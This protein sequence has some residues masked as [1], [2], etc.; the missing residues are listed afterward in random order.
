MKG[1]ALQNLSLLIEAL[2][3]ANRLP[4]AEIA[5]NPQL[6][7]DIKNI[8]KTHNIEGVL[9]QL[10]Q[11]LS[12]QWQRAE[13]AKALPALN[14]DSI[15]R[16]YAQR[17]HER[18]K[19]ADA[20]VYHTK[21]VG[22]DTPGRFSRYFK[23]LA[24]N[25][26]TAIPDKA[27]G[28]AE[29]N[30]ETVFNTVWADGAVKINVT[31]DPSLLN[32]YMDYT[33]YRV[34]YATYLSIPTLSEM[35][36]R[37]LDL[38]F[39]KFAKVKSPNKKFT[40]AAEQFFKDEQIPSVTRDALFFALMS[41]R[42]SLTVPVLKNGRLHFNAFNDTQFSYGLAPGYDILTAPYTSTRVGP[43]YCLGAQLKHGTSAFFLCPGF[44]PLFGIGLNRVPM[45]RQAADAWN[46][47]VHVLK[48]LLVRSQ[49]IIEKMEGD[50]QT[51]T[52][53]KRM[54]SMLQTL[55]QTMGAGTVIEQPRGTTL[56]ILNNNIG[57]GT[58]DIA[59]V[60]KEFVGAVTGVA[61]EYFFGGSNANY[62]M[63]AFNIASTNENL[64]ARYQ[65]KQLEPLLRFMLNTAIAYDE[66]FK[67]LGIAEN[68]FDLE[69]ES[70]YDETGQE[71]A[72]LNGKRTETLIRQ[73]EY[74]ELEKQ[75]KQEGLLSEEISFEGLA[76]DH[77]GDDETGNGKNEKKVDAPSGGGQLTKPLS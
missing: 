70:I 8:F 67:G 69:F 64:R 62:S 16:A 29:K 42:G 38:V 4:I 2:D 37:P 34:N 74:S 43:L 17:E 15:L 27:P 59:S 19:R 63:S 6:K 54:K 18:L 23:A 12:E 48:I 58:A 49:V 73:R 11:D 45:L 65:V 55:T 36:D 24:R 31:A 46:L 28:D 32:S 10:T 52:M 77:D 22:E 60:F 14:S 50:I 51:D 9:N 57:P 39:K 47:Y 56:D 53:L 7:A 1:N 20:P 26:K 76:P 66:R 5:E 71:K 25:A 75:F 3:K 68:D 40:E 13:S 44:E 33:P 21:I 35:T 61:P 41:C 30:F 72:D